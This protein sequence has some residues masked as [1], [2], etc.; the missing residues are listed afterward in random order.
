MTS[1]MKTIDGNTAAAHVAY[2]L[3]DAAA[4]YPITPSSPMGELCDEWAASGLEN[5]FGQVMTVRQMQIVLP[6]G[7]PV[8]TVWNGQAFS[9]RYP[10]DGTFGVEASGVCAA[11]DAARGEMVLT[12]RPSIKRR[13]GATLPGS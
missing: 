7:G 2:A 11:E 9:V 5:V 10:L 3:S 1:K 8:V 4:I 6:P 12:A 13:L